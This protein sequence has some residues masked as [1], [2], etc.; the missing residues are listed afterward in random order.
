MVATSTKGVR[1]DS[2]GRKYGMGG[3]EDAAT[4]AGEG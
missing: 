1:Y 2:T 4:K 3:C